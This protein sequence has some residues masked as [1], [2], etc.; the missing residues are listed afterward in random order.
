MT[1]AH[2]EIAMLWRWMVLALISAAPP[3]L[4][5]AQPAWKPTRP[6]TLII[7]NAP[8]GTSDRTARELQRIIM[9]H[10]LVEVPV[11]LVN[12]PGGNGTVALNQLRSSPGDGHTL[13]IMNG[14]TLSAQIM[15]LTPYGHADFTPLAA[16]ANEYFGVNV[17]ASSPI[18]SAPEMVE[19]LKKSPDA[20]TFA[21]ASVSGNNYLSLVTALKKAGI[22]VKRLKTV[23]FAGGGQ[24][25]M[26]LL[27]GHVDAISTGLSNMADY[28]QQ[29][30]MR[31]L[32][33]TAPQRMWGSFANVP[34]WKELGVN[35]VASGWRG[36]MAP[37]GLTPAQVAYWEDV[38]RKVIESEEWKQEL[39]DNYWVS[40]YVSA[41][42]TRRRLDAEYAEM[43]QI[44]GDLGMVK[45]K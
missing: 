1:M 38:I 10:R 23:T 5:A 29:G 30:K 13:L 17:I 28:V 41:A 21:T 14:A 45:A 43:K 42:D 18:A 7:P 24:S 33:I 20:L 19:R 4:L 40:T 22:D 44:L 32:V 15:G 3:V 9:T 39:K 31:T 6:I 12:R 26:A 34:T 35:A 27:G 36:V 37:K 2:F 11:V 8:G 25:T 16:M